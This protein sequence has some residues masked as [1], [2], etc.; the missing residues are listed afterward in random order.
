LPIE[1]QSAMLINPLTIPVEEFRNC[2]FWGD[3]LNYGHLSVYW[4]ISI[5]I[6]WIGFAWFQR[7]RKG[8]ADVL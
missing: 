8:F 7:V 5:F 4:V 6:S 2:L 1:F 3:E